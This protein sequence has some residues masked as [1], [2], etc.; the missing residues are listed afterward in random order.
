MRRFLAASVPFPLIYDFQSRDWGM[1]VV[2]V[3]TPVVRFL[4]GVIMP[5]VTSFREHSEEEMFTLL[6]YQ[7][8]NLFSNIDMIFPTLA[9]IAMLVVG[10]QTEPNQA[11][12]VSKEFF[13]HAFV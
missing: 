6:R 3:A 10:F 9:T 12:V 1:C 8:I 13:D 7:S 2:T 11:N 4:S 5:T